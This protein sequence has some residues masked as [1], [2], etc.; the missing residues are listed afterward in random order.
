MGLAGVVEPD[1]NRVATA[2]YSLDHME[3]HFASTVDSMTLSHGYFRQVKEA[4]VESKKPLL[5][6]A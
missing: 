6:I 2:A 5:S 1:F 4:G 3:A